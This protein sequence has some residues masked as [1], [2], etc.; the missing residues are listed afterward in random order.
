MTEDWIAPSG[1]ALN[2]YVNVRVICWLCRGEGEIEAKSFPSQYPVR[3]ACPLC[4]GL[5]H[6]NAKVFLRKLPRR[7]IN[8]T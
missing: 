4:E 3:V 6:L 5:G 8:G 2:K 1:L 7:E